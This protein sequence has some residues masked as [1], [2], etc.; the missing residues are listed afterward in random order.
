MDGADNGES[1][2]DETYVDDDCKVR[3]ALVNPITVDE[4]GEVE[5]VNEHMH[6][7]ISHHKVDGNY[8]D[9]ICGPFF[10]IRTDCG[11]MESAMF[12]EE[13]KVEAITV[14]ITYEEI[15]VIS[16]EVVCDLATID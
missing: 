11:S 12:Y 15:V 8:V 1:H 6:V 13:S 14:A 5:I 2:Y 16:H 3:C 9:Q 7:E 10:E 4:F